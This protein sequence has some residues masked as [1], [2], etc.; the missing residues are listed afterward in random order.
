MDCRRQGE[1]IGSLGKARPIEGMTL[2]A[3]AFAREVAKQLQVS[4]GI[5]KA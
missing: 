3:E 4:G 5:G 1:I 2:D